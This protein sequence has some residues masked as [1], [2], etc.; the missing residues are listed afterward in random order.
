MRVIKNYLTQIKT[1]LGQNTKVLPKILLLFVF[2]SLL[3]ILG[4]SIVIPYMS[5]ILNYENLN[6]SSLYGFDFSHFSKNQLIIF[7]SIFLIS[8]YAIKSIVS[9]AVKMYILKYSYKV[10]FDL[11]TYLTEIFLK[12]KFQNFKKKKLSDF[13]YII[14][15]LTG[16]FH[17]NLNSLLI[18]LSECIIFG[19]IIILL[20]LKNFVVLFFALFFIALVF[21]SLDLIFKKK[22]KNYGIKVNIHANAMIQNIVDSV[23]GFRTIKIL[24][25]QYF[26]IDKLKENI[27][28]FTNYRIRVAFIKYLPKHLF[29]TLF[30][31]L[32]CISIIISLEFKLSLNEFLI[33]L[34]LFSAASVRLIPCANSISTN[35]SE[36]RFKRNSINLLYNNLILFENFE[37][38]TIGDTEKNKLKFEKLKFENVVFSFSEDKKIFDNVNFEIN[39]GDRVAIIGKS[40]AGKTT[41]VNLILGFLSTNSGNIT[42]NNQDLKKQ[43]RNWHKIISYT[44]QDGFLFGGK[45][46][47]NITFEDEDKFISSEKLEYAIKKAGIDF[48]E[49]IQDIINKDLTDMGDNISGGQKQRVS[50]GRMFYFDKEVIFLDEP[51]SAL[52]S[53]TEELIISAINEIEKNKTIFVIA[54]NSKI[55]DTCNVKL[56]LENNKINIVKNN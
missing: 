10:A 52:D 5:I 7:I 8:V 31:M 53:K 3:E 11:R 56:I 6:I 33:T 26:F 43:A 30:I 36:L 46:K 16:D 17:S 9:I 13:V 25:K 42:I 23:R 2:S 18:L 55:I 4:L 39:K 15:N 50:L 29:E 40:G 48:E 28:N 27:K 44:P 45:I 32:I 19:A 51:T 37:T 14:E 54:H 47:T 24:N 49:N 35:F 20:G 38:D 1:L 41:L 12:T 22:L 21:I 34:T